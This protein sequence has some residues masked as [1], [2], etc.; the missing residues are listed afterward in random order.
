MFLLGFACGMMVMLVL[1]AMVSRRDQEAWIDIVGRYQLITASL[2]RQRDAA[3][4]AWAEATE[5]L[6]QEIEDDWWKG[7]T[8]AQAAE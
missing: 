7:G 8:D 4:A 3:I 6:E 2:I 1:A 5:R